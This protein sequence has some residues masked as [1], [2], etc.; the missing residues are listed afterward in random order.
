MSTDISAHLLYGIKYV[1]EDMNFCIKG[2]KN[3]EEMYCNKVGVLKD[4]P[5][6]LDRKNEVIRSCNVEIETYDHL[7]G[8][9]TFIY[10]KRLNI[11]SD[12]YE[13]NIIGR[14][15]PMATVRDSKD[16]LEFCNRMGI[17]F[18]NPKWYLALNYIG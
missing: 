17:P 1:F 18:S 14:Y 12:T 10:V 5:E 2:Y 4:D 3:W 11:E 7:N 8:L 13:D 9:S 16:I 15:L 6:Y